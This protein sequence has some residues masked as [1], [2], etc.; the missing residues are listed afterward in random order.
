MLLRAPLFVLVFAAGC[1]EASHSSEP[2]SARPVVVA[3]D[4][5]LAEPSSPSA[6]RGPVIPNTDV[7]DTPAN[8]AVIDFCERYR[9]ALEA[10]DTNTLLSLA[11]P[12]Y[13]E[14]GGTPDPSDDIDHAGLEAY[15]KGMFGKVER[16]RLDLRYREIRDEG[17]RIVVSVI[18]SSTF[19]I[20]GKYRRSVSDNELVLERDGSSYRISSGM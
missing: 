19:E 9:T 4:D 11:S 12:R 10:R 2:R 3:R 18:Q 5:S 16:I 7:P 15:L 20:D 14:D 17:A 8:R 13:H 6:S 1:G